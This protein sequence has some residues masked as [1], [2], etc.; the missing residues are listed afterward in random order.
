[1]IRVAVIVKSG[2]LARTR[3]SKLSATKLSGG[4]MGGGTVSALSV[5]GNTPNV[6]VYICRQAHR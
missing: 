6:E 2:Q 5:S 1:L 4:S 3:V